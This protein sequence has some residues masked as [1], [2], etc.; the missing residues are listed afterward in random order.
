MQA[1]A[2]VS[3]ALVSHA[4]L[5]E[6]PCAGAAGCAATW[7]SPYQLRACQPCGA[8]QLQL[9]GS[10]GQVHEA[11][12][13]TCCTLDALAARC[14]CYSDSSSTLP[15]CARSYR[16]DAVRHCPRSQA[17]GK[18][19]ISGNISALASAYSSSQ[20][21]QVEARVEA[22]SAPG[23]VYRGSQAGGTGWF[24]QSVVLTRR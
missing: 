20:R 23:P 5:E 15:C 8:G 2:L 1:H 24:S 9:L 6:R 13:S 7:A 3:H 17:A 22:L 4:G 19:S 10:P 18:E 16:S 12:H 11:R 14:W 21:P